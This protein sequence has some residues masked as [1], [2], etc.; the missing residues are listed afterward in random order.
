M[1]TAVVVEDIVA[2]AEHHGKWREEEE[3]AKELLVDNVLKLKHIE[4]A[5]IVERTTWK[6]N[7]ED[8]LWWG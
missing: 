7:D 4:Q 5:A 8:I 3:E 2:I 1:N 6:H